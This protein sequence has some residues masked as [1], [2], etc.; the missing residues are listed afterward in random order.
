MNRRS[1]IRFTTPLILYSPVGQI[2]NNTK[3]D[4]SFIMTVS[5]T[6]DTK[7]MGVT[8]THEH[9]FSIFGME[10]E[11]NT[12]YDI[13][14]LM[15]VVLP[16]LQEAKS[17]GCK[18]II[19]CTA[20][21][22]GRNVE[23]LKTLAEKSGLNIITNTGIYGAAN[24][25]YI[26]SYVHSETAE[27]IAN[28]WID[29]WKNGI[30]RTGIRPGFIK[31]GFNS[32]PLSAVDKK[33]LEAGALTH[34]ATGL[35]IAAHTADNPEAAYDQLNILRKKNVSPTA[36]IWTH[37][38]TVPA[39]EPL[40]KAAKMGA[41]ISFDGY[42][43]QKQDWFLKGV[44]ALKNA[45]YLDRV[46]L[47]HDGNGY[48]QKGKMPSRLSLDL[49]NDFLPALIKSGFTQSDIQLL[50]VTNPSNAFAVKIRSI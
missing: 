17:A 44:H 2:I 39:S 16:F 26:P 15:S 29:E 12:E 5:G 36:W 31:L 47:S 9:L 45:G 42:Q 27:Q 48:P 34:L 41:W 11:E 33:L 18:T 32:G 20:A 19:D 13:E 35:T 30:E 40:L 4:K 28:R 1:F 14:E 23:I 24:G 43:A 37:A 10:A 22:F 21:Y 6:L 8:L 46:L 3:N 25:K 7:A 49:L 50:T 38:H